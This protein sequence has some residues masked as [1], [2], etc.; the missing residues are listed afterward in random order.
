[1][2]TIKDI[3]KAAG[4]SHG[5]VSNVLNKRGG[6]SYEKIRLVEQ[7]ARAMGYSIDEKA[8]SLRRGTA[9]ALSVILPTLCE[10]RYAD[11]Y[12][13]ILRR[14][15][16][17]GYAVR[18][19]LTDDMPHRERRA[20]EESVALK[21]SSIL[22]VSCLQNHKKEYAAAA[23][24]KLPVLFLER[25]TQK[26]GFPS[27][28]FDMQEAAG[29]IYAEIK[30]T[31]K[32][33]TICVVMRNPQFSDQKQFCDA[34]Q[35]RLHLPES[36]LYVCA[37][38]NQSFAP[39]ELLQRKNIPD[40]IVCTDESLA[41][42]VSR[43]FYRAC[44]PLPEIHTLS[45]LR[46]VTDPRFSGLAFNYR[47][48]GH[49]A[50]EAALSGR[51]GKAIESRIY[52]TSCAYAP[53]PAPA[54][55]KN[56]TLHVLAHETPS[57]LALQNLLPQFSKRYGAEVEL[58]ACSMDEVFGELCSERAGYWD[59]VRLDPSSLPYFGPR[60]F[61]PLSDI[62]SGI[63]SEFNRFLPGLLN[64]FSGVRGQL[65]AM[66]FDIAVQ[67]LF[68]QKSAFEDIGQIRAF[69]EE[70]GKNLEVP[71]TYEDFDRVARFFSQKH[72]PDS[73]IR[74]GSSLAAAR[75]TSITAEYLPRLLAAGGLSYSS[76]GCLNL[77]TH[78][79]LQTLKEYIAF[80]A[81]TSNKR[82]QNWSDIAQ[83]FVNG[84]TATAIL[85]ANHS[86]HFIRNQSANAGIEIGFAS[87]PGRHPLLGGGSLCINRKTEFAEDAY[88]FL[89]W[90]T[91]EQIAPELVMLGGISACRCVYEH[92]EILDTYPWLA[93]LPGN[94]RLGIRQPILSPMNISINQREF[95]TV[96][97]QHLLRALAKQESP[98]QALES[99][100]R[101]LDTILNG[102]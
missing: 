65:Y 87:I 51:Q 66:P 55:P 102:R 22:T 37:R 92:R 28:S 75:P 34:L 61:M 15:E 27:F 60:Q 12:T 76:S 32:P 99:T 3:A 52:G 68:Y 36:N 29:Q 95:E 25:P 84:Q 85:F 24:R 49:E 21:V 40:I 83:N 11:L 1:M 67:M 54:I 73:P 72:R 31:A 30:R 33:D 5:T 69:F 50:V 98:E 63:A 97:G 58:H 18:L 46:P 23:A 88:A 35:T 19:F 74:Y 16:T 78:A 38:S 81:Y 77:L 48:M 57:I 26:A 6:V 89:R 79:A 86:S 39:L 90:A 43:I 82:V 10:Q 70:T 96:L 71:A 62:D 91:G 8:S 44:L 9:N 13:G 4:V 17:A 47:R 41:E 80:S 56:R 45:S 64:E 2:P 53:V 20:I 14:A 101:E 42:R 93:E 7:T 100:Q 94:I 59:V